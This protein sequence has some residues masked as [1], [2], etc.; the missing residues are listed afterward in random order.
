MVPDC[1]QVERAHEV[2]T[3]PSCGQSFT[4]L[5]VCQLM[6]VTASCTCLFDRWRLTAGKIPAKTVAKTQAKSGCTS[7]TFHMQLY[8]QAGQGSVR[9]SR[10]ASRCSAAEQCRVAVTARW[11]HA[12]RQQAQLG[13]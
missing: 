5:H 13:A 11:V 2:Q 3:M 8:T 10:V 12:G 6:Q 9:E 7:H 1:L 4:A